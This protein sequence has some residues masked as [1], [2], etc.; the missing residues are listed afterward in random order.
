VVIPRSCKVDN[1][2]AKVTI[3]CLFFR[4]S[5]TKHIS[6]LSVILTCVMLCSVKE[7]DGSTSIR[8]VFVPAGDE[9]E[10]RVKLKFGDK[11]IPSGSKWKFAFFAICDCDRRP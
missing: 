10:L 11:V 3:L 2:G 1:Y 9:H 6:A 5:H 4:S 7:V 8:E